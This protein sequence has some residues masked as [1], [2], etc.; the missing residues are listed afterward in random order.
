MHP[1]LV[2]LLVD[3]TRIE[4]R[5]ACKHYKL[6]SKFVKI[7]GQHVP[8]AA[9]KVNRHSCKFQTLFASSRHGIG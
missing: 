7:Y 6:R 1:L 4:Y 8:W 2:L 9:S 5:I 3:H